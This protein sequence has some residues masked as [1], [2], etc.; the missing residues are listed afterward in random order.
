MN[1][2]AD[3]LF[4]E[5][6]ISA[7]E[8]MEDLADKYSIK[9][10]LMTACKLVL[11]D[12]IPPMDISLAFVS[13]SSYK[14]K[15]IAEMS[16]SSDVE[17]SSDYHEEYTLTNIDASKFVFIF[18]NTEEKTLE[19]VAIAISSRLCDDLINHKYNREIELSSYKGTE[20]SLK[21]KEEHNER[22]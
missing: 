18:M 2:Y 9:G 15:C 7:P 17:L 11:S 22:I 16:T 1:N 21:R 19:D 8:E 3:R 20:H 5:E 6:I 13:D 12:N 4:F 14:V 10:D